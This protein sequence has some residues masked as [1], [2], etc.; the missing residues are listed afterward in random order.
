MKNITKALII[1]SILPVISLLAPHAQ[2]ASVGSVDQNVA[3][4]HN[5][6]GLSPK[7]LKLGLEAYSFA[8]KKNKVKKPLLAIAD[9]TQPSD[10]KRLYIMDLRKKE[11]VN[12][13]RVAHGMNSGNRYATQFS[14][15]PESHETSLGVYTTDITY[16]GKHGVSL[17]ING[18]EK[19]NSNAYSR[20]VV[21]HSAP[22]MTDAFVLAHNKAGR[23][24]GCFAM[25]PAV[26][27]KVINQL[28]GGSVIFA[29]AKAEQN[30]SN[31][32]AS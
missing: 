19:S 17:R 27:P 21:M 25:S 10:E 23:S 30:D 28:K 3:D 31:L 12:K 16:S 8:E 7:A 4:Y 14:N 15:S 32:V 22:Y 11:V 2:A 29:Y 26:A 6:Q 20:S 18:L 24:W 9:Y 1:S 13:V 5:L